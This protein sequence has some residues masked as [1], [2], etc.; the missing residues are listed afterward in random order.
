MKVTEQT[1][2]NP[3]TGRNVGY[4]R[5]KTLGLIPAKPQPAKSLETSVGT[6]EVK[7]VQVA[8]LYFDDGMFTP[9]PMEHDCLDG[10][11]SS[12][13]G[14]M[15]ATNI[16]VI[17]KPG[18]GKSTVSLDF[19]SRAKRSGSK[20]LFISGE[21]GR[22]DMYRY[23]KRFP[24]FA[25]LDTLFLGDYIDK[26]PAIAIEQV[27]K[28]GYD[29]VLIDSWAEVCIMLKD[30]NPW[31]KSETESW[32]LDLLEKNN[33]GKN[34]AG[35]FTCFLIIQQVTKSG[36]ALGSN[37][38]KHMTSG[39]LE[40]FRSDEQTH[41]SFSKNR[42]GSTDLEVGYSIRREEVVYYPVDALEEYLDEELEE[43][44]EF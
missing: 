33:E 21:M 35:K 38:L 11:I 43:V 37:R 3:A 24:E 2:F 17:G 36:D 13:G 26:N 31:T 18:V 23:C 39:M 12:D 19:L 28:R 29:M 4:A 5:A 16:I 6:F 10:F 32:V 9:I 44:E 8:D 27:L 30:T 42:V 14:F 20:V 15:P 1:Y 7:T 40:L 41:M 22:I 34:D 25:T